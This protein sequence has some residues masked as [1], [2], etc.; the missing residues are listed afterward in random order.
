MDETTLSQIISI[1]DDVDDMTIAT[2]RGDGY[3]QATTVSYVNDG[4][5][6]YFGTA[7]SSQKASNIAQSNKVSLTINRT[8]SSWDEIEGLS[9]AGLATRI[10]DPAEQRKIGDLMFAKFPQIAKYIPPESPSEELALFR[11]D[12]KVI[13][14]LDYRKEFGHCELVQV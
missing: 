7:A 4:L 3:P 13:S 1:M 10:T 11:I 8:Y 2:L 5:T 9:L 14:L 12:P 6:I